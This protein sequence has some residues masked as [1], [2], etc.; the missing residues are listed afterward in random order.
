MWNE[1]RNLS[2][3]TEE[4]MSIKLLTCWEFHLGQ[5]RTKT[6]SAYALDF[7]QI[8]AMHDEQRK[9]MRTYV[10]MFQGLKDTQKGK[11]Y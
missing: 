3:K 2:F 8:H 4:Q 9:I 1:L 11:Q 6:Q 10:N 5:A 7:C